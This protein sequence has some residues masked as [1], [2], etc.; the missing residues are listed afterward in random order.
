M[1]L[2]S[3]T[4][5]GEKTTLTANDQVFA[6]EANPQLLAQAIRV[7]LANERQGTA[8][9][10]TR[11]EVARTRKKWF[12][13][14]GTGNA[15]HGARTPNIFVG[16]GVSHGPNGDQ[17]W[18]LNMTQAMRRQALCQALSHQ[19]KNVVVCDSIE[20]LDGKTATT[21]KV[22]K[23]IVPESGRTLV[24]LAESDARLLRGLRNLP[25]VLTVTA[26]R[27]NVMQVAAADKIV[28][29]SHSVKKLETRLLGEV[30]A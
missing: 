14:K 11:A 18:S 15:R 26:G 10:K 25:S 20:K 12:K 28:M 8:K 13:Q 19:V 27:V 7:Y 29:T 21:V 17:N 30:A 6:A 9:V 5:T 16:G 22:L 3:I 1:K 4:A 24:V 23:K 2:H